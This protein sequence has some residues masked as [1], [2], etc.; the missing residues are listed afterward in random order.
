M[1]DGE[2]FLPEEWLG[3]AFAQTRHELGRVDEFQISLTKS[4]GFR[5]RAI[6]INSR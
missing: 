4:I 2:L 6:S 5:K 3:A 1:V